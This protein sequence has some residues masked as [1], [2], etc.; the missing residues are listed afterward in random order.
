M[1]QGTPLV[2]LIGD[3]SARGYRSLAG[4]AMSLPVVTLAMLAYFYN[5]YAPWWF[6]E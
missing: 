4:E 5:P 1:A 3:V 6:A 2:S